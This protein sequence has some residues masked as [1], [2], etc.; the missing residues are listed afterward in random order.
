[1]KP[2]KILIPDTIK[3]VNE[4]L[5]K[6]TGCFAFLISDMQWIYSEPK[7]GKEA[8][9]LWSVALYTIYHDYGCDYIKYILDE[10]HS[11]DAYMPGDLKKCKRHVDDVVKIFRNNIAHG[12]FDSCSREKM[13]RLVF[14]YDKT[15]Q[16]DDIDQLTDDQWLHVAN[17]LKDDS[18]FL[19]D[20]LYEWA[21][22]FDKSPIPVSVSKPRLKFGE[23]PNFTVSISER[24][25]FDSLDKDYSSSQ[26]QSAR[27]ILDDAFQKGG[28]NKNSLDT[29]TEWQNMIQRDFLDEKIKCPDDIIKILR[30]CLYEI[31]N[32]P[33]RSSVEIAAA[34]GFS[35]DGL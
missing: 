35:F 22:K 23:S 31:H 17:R 29:L 3:K 11:P 21:D 32:P 5:L 15:I 26:L 7:S 19:V 25:V 34:H 4:H 8:F 20:T 10:S 27:K 12:I 33:S 30:N 18:D 14:K 6:K 24:V 13:Q 16:V 1:M 28:G 9:E 2:P